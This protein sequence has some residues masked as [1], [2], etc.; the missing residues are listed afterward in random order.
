MLSMLLTAV[1]SIVPAGPAEKQD[2]D[3]AYRKAQLNGVPLMVIVSSDACPACQTLKANTI[4]E[5]KSSGDLEDVSLVVVNKDRDPELA[6]RL[7]RGRMIPQIIVYSKGGAGW[8][9]L[10]LTGYQTRDGVR[11]LIRKAVNLTRIGT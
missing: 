3:E 9:R 7:M 4:A 11:T 10:Q 5:M 2:Y 1:I 8:K 6:S